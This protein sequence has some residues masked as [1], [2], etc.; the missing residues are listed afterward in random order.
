MTNV[1]HLVMNAFRKRARILAKKRHTTEQVTSKLRDSEIELAQGLK[2][3]QVCKKLEVTEQIYLP[4]ITQ[5]KSDKSVFCI[6]RRQT[7]VLGRKNA[8]AQW[9]SIVFSVM[10]LF[11]ILTL[12]LACFMWEIRAVTSKEICSISVFFVWR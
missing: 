11:T 12:L 8:S 3:P 6:V 10:D 1:S 7:R 2:I 9:G 4:R 5:I